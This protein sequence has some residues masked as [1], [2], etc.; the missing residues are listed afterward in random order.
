[1]MCCK[2]ENGI[3]FQNGLKGR[4]NLAQGNALGIRVIIFQFA[5]KG[6]HNYIALTGRTIVGWPLTQPVGL[7]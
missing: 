3:G 6:Q 5:L 2:W 4:C 1:M 7:G